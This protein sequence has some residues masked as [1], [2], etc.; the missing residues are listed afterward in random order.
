MGEDKGLLDIKGKPLVLRLIEALRDQVDRIGVLTNQLEDY[1]FLLE[2]DVFLKEDIIK[3]CGPLGGIHT[4]LSLGEDGFFISCDLP[5]FDGRIVPFMKERLE[6]NWGCFPY[7]EGFFE[8]LCGIYTQKMFSQIEKAVL[9]KELRMQKL[10]AS[11]G[12]KIVKVQ[13]KELIRHY[14]KDIF[15]NMNTRELYDRLNKEGR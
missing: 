3:G 7:E 2:K 10:L 11:F 4:G 9:A 14:G 12:E 6:E 8:P 13:R 1:T 5:F 15:L